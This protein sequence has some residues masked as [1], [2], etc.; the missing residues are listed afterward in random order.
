MR[1]MTDCRKHGVMF[2]GCQPVNERTALLPCTFN[3]LHIFRIVFRQRRDHDLLARIQV[4]QRRIGTI[5]LT[6][7]NRMPGHEM[8]NLVAKRLACGGHHIGFGTARIGDHGTRLQEGR[9]V[10]QQAFGLRD[11]CGQQHQIRALHRRCIADAVDDAKRLRALQR[12][13]TA[14]DAEHFAHRTRTLQRQR[15]RAADQAG[16]ENDDFIE[17]GHQ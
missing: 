13:A 17:G 2:L 12:C 16:A 15:E 14:T 4:G 9:D 10:A 3:R 8:R 6:P 5:L 1:Q 11:R 7:C